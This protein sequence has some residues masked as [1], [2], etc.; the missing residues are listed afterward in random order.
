MYKYLIRPLLFQLDPE[1]VHHL[2][3]F[4][5]RL[6]GRIPGVHAG[7]R[8]FTARRSE[9]DSIT[10]AGLQFKGR[11]GLAAGFD[12]NADF[13]HDF[14][15][16][17]FSFVEIGTVTPVPQ[18]GNPKPRLFRLQR[19]NALINRMGF[20]SKGVEHAVGKVEK[21][22]KEPDNRRQYWEKYAYTQ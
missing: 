22:G 12:K 2:V 15:M 13:F 11:V 9:I 1:R 3:V 21:E 14:A 4:L 10:I 7:V 16:F 8:Y 19:D 6:I 20:N 5:V 17:G 18:P